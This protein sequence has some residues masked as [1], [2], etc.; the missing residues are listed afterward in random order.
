MLLRFITIN[1]I[2]F[3]LLRLR[4]RQVVDK[5]AAQVGDNI[6]LMSDLQ[7]QKLQAIQAGVAASEKKWI[8]RYSKK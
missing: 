1:F 8:V 2:I 6:I 4:Q 7:A 3:S 5:V